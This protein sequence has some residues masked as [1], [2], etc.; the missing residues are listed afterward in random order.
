MV[1]LPYCIYGI[2]LLSSL[3]MFYGNVMMSL[4]LKYVSA[5]NQA[6]VVV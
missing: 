4:R 1:T 2:I 3:Y 6:H 5:P